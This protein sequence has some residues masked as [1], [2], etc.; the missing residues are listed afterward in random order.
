GSAVRWCCP[1]CCSAEWSAW[2]AVGTTTGPTP[3]AIR[4][5]STPT[6]PAAERTTPGATARAETPPGDRTSAAA[7]TAAGE[8]WAGETSAAETSVGSERW[9]RQSGDPV[10]DPSRVF[11]I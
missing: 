2:A 10:S 3:P 4:Q 9:T 11:E 6:D 8:T 1:L 5:G 7:P